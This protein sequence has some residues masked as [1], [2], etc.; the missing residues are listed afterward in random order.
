M[1]KEL[2]ALAQRLKGE[3]MILQLTQHVQNY[4]YEHNKAP[5]GSFHE[6]M[7]LAQKKREE[8]LLQKEQQE[9]SEKHKLIRE[10]VI[11][12]KEMLKSDSKTKD[13]RRSISE[14]S[15]THRYRSYSS[16][17]NSEISSL[18]NRCHLYP[19]E[20]LEHRTSE[21]LYFQNFGKK[22]LKGCC[23]GRFEQF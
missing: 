17:E 20:C 8:D 7:L 5:A 4:L 23:L 19:N 2:V 3:E 13:I 21:T 22:I 1:T 16:S 18:I 14:S 10:E 11:K 6:Q 15:P 9:L 12:R